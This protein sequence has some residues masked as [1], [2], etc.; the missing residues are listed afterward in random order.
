MTVRLRL[1]S[2]VVTSPDAV[3][4][5]YRLFDSAGACIAGFGTQ[6][7]WTTQAAVIA[8]AQIADS[9]GIRPVPIA[10]LATGHYPENPQLPPYAAQRRDSG[11]DLAV[12]GLEHMVWDVERALEAAGGKVL[13]LTQLDHAHPALDRKVIAYALK[14]RL[15][16]CIMYDC[17]HLPLRENMRRTAAFVRRNQHRC[18]VQGIV[19]HVYEG[20][21]ERPADTYTKP[22]DAAE[23]MRRVQPFLLVANLGTEHRVCRRG[24]RPRYRPG[25]ARRIAAAL[26]QRVLVLHGSSC[27]TRSQLRGLAEDGIIQVNVWTML[28][29]V[30]ARALFR[31]LRK[32][33]RAIA[34]RPALEHYTVKSMRDAWMPPVIDCMK[35]YMLAF[36]YEK[37]ARHRGELRRLS[38]R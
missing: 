10:I 22:E 31:H 30:G 4:A 1:G 23:Y 36:G 33:E 18:L 5:I 24:Y 26:G 2:G 6:N 35:Q 37:L 15:L 13:A 17:S 16:S 9:L 27:L 25:L 19:D 28:E 34:R 3:R 29:K 20:G 7:T 8:A 21:G 12:Q 14:N 11:R 32:S 38:A